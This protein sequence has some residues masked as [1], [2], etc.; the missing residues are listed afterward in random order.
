MSEYSMTNRIMQIHLKSGR[1]FALLTLPPLGLAFTLLYSYQSAALI[2]LFLI[3]H[4][5]CWRLWLDEQL[6]QLLNNESELAEFDNGM[7]LLWPQKS[8]ET[9]TLAARW[10]GTKRLFYRAIISLISLWLL[11]LWL[12]IYQAITQVD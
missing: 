7:A 3:T 10:R 1:Y 4:Y 8:R 2:L 11:S 9:R 12:I 5:Y 6:F